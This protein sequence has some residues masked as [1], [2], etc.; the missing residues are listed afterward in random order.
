MNV[1]RGLALK[2]TAI[3]KRAGQ[4]PLLGD[5]QSGRTSYLYQKVGPKGEH[6]KYG[7][8]YSPATRYTQAELGG[9]RLKVLANG[10]REEMLRLER[11]LHSWL[12]IG[13]EEAQEVYLR[14]QL[15]NGLRIPPYN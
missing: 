8:S 13:P 9:G 10:S 4:G 12:P 15:R 6:L 1:E 3:L 7:I 2:D 5:L 11:G 14:V